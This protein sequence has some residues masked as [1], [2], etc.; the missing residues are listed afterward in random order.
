MIVFIVLTIKIE[1]QVFL[2][3]IMIKK[4]INKILIN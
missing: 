4:K 1:I 3:W 2:K